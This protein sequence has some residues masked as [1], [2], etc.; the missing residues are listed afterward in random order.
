MTAAEL[1]GDATT[2]GSNVVTVVKVNGTAVPVNSSADQLLGTSASATGAWLSIPNCGLGNALQYSTSTH[3]FSCGSAGASTR[4]WPF[5]FRGLVQAGVAGF[6][7]NL[8]S[9]N[10]PTPTNA[11]G[12]DPAA[13][14]EWPAAAASDYAWWL[15]DLPSGYVSN[16]NISYTIQS[17]SADSTNYVT[18]TPFW[19]CV[20]TGVVDVPSWTAVST[21]NITSAATSGRTTTTGTITPTCAAG[22]QAGV[23]LAINTNVA[24]H[25]M[26]SPFDLISVTFSVQGGM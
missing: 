6:T 21:F 9:A 12:T 3:T 22:S 25:V 8:P 5:V 13:V 26:T 19:A 24:S 20:S 7:A 1:S 2:S 11:G 18:V 4:T 17:R 15:F 23:K 14:L 16:A 10:A